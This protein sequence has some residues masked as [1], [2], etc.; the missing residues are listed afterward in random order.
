MAGEPESLHTKESLKQRAIRHDY[1]RLLML[2]DGVFAIAITLLALD[3]T[4]PD[5]WDGSVAALASTTGRPLIGYLFGF[6]LVGAF[7]FMHRR[8]FAQMEQVDGGITLLNLLLLGL[9]GLTPFV[10]RMIAEAGPTR[11]MPFYM[12]EVAGVLGSAALIRG[13]GA[14][15]PR[16][17][18]P[19]VDR[20]RWFRELVHLA[21]AALILGGVGAWAIVEHE[22]LTGNLM[23]ILIVILAGSRA[24]VRRFENQRS[25]T[26]RP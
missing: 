8:T 16:L 21:A 24:L 11:A 12:V 10:A 3:L 19:Q 13:W 1:D 18:H 20:R 15:H 7:W 5:H 23:L 14:I 6:I 4:L 17:L 9:V 22:K 25:S 26:S 2:S